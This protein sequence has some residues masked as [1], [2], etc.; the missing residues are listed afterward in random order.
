[1]T[2]IAF[3]FIATALGTGALTFGL[4]AL[5]VSPWPLLGL[6]LVV[7]WA[8]MAIRPAEPMLPSGLTLYACLFVTAF[9]L[10]LPESPSPRVGIARM[11][12]TLLLLMISLVA[13]FVMLIRSRGKEE[14][15]PWLIAAIAMAVFV[16]FISGDRGGADSMRSA[17]LSWLPPWLAEAVLFA[18]RKSIHILFYGIM[19]WTVYRAGKSV[20][21]SVPWAA[22]AFSVAHGGFDEYRQFAASKTRFGTP[23]DILF[24]LGGALLILALG[25]A[26][27][28]SAP[29][30]RQ[31]E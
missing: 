5:D 3:A 11:A 6:F 1:M 31:M 12:V 10:S 8:L 26:F 4:A 22:V 23:T 21:V 20:G 25:G 28:K 9:I 29:R 27:R 16:A 18:V 14:A 24:D 17:L 7:G 19:A 30:K 15:F 13:F 2:R